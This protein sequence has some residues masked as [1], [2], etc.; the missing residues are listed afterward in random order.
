MMMFRLGAAC[1]LSAI[2]AWPQLAGTETKEARGKRVVDE[3]VEALGGSR[4]LQLA[5]RTETGRAYSFYREQLAGLSRA[6]IYTRYLRQPDPPPSPPALYVRERQ[7]FGEKED[8]AILFDEKA[9]YQI[10]FR[11]ARPMP[12]ALIARYQDTTRRNVFYILRQR[13]KEPGLLI[14]S[15]G[16]EVVDNQPTEVV[17]FTDTD[18]ITVTVYFHRSTKLPLKQVFFRR[19]PVT[20]E[21]NEEVTVFGKYRNVGG[22]VQWPWSITRFRNGEKIF[23]LFSD[24][25]K[26]DQGLTDTL[27]ILPANVRMLPEAK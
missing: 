12:A 5:D 2:L 22:G 14:E 25:V 6:T 20:R 15:R 27:F 18:N 9:G 24:D 17:D 10:T 7:S 1:G 16:S 26:T 3:A 21:R 11:G 19:D 13:L 23:E 4:F 8:Y